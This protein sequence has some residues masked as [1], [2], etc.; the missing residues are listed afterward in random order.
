M[1]K[2]RVNGGEE[3]KNNRWLLRK[4]RKEEENEEKRKD[5]STHNYKYQTNYSKI[6]LN[7]HLFSHQVKAITWMVYDQ[8]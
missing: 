6:I 3:K 2:K 1:T 7:I 8:K 4:K 5:K